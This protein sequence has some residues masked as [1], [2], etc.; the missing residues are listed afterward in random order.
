MAFENLDNDP[1]L[2]PKRLGSSNSAKTSREVNPNADNNDC[3]PLSDVSTQD[4]IENDPEVLNFPKQPL[5]EYLKEREDIKI[6]KESIPDSFNIELSDN[7]IN[8]CGFK[9]GN[10]Y[11]YI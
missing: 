8:F 11:H 5:E 9:K 2:H 10:N 6:K 1:Y 3:S 7:K 4:L